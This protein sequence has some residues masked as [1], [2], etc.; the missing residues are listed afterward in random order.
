M[1][2]RQ[3]TRSVRTLGWRS[4]LFYAL[5]HSQLFDLIQFFASRSVRRSVD[6]RCARLVKKSII[7]M[8]LGWRSVQTLGH[9]DARW[10]TLG[11]TQVFDLIQFFASRSVGEQ[12]RAQTP[13]PYAR[14]YARCAYTRAYARAR[15]PPEGIPA[16][17][18]KFHRA[19]GI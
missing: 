15:G 12:P 9:F 7:S 14:A 4:V 2:E 19:I 5:G 11:H 8:T 3:N 13:R 10:R 16:P 6:A 1:T 17:N 18:R